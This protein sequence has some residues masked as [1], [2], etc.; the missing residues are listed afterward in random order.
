MCMILFEVYDRPVFWES[1][2]GFGVSSG[3]FRDCTLIVAEV[4]LNHYS[5]IKAED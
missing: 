1:L 3:K 5:D 2:L 4:V